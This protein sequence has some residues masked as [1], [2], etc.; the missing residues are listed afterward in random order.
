VRFL[1]ICA[2]D[3][4]LSTAI[5]EAVR[6]ATLDGVLTAASLMVGAPAAAQAVDIARQL[7]GLKVG[8]HVVL[9]DGQA[10]LPKHRIPALVDD[11]GRFRNGMLLD[12]VQFY[13]RRGV[14]EQLAAEIRAQFAAFARTGLPL[15]H[16]NAHK[17]F[18]LHPGILQLIVEIGRPY[19]ACAVRVPQEPLWFSSREGGIASLAS[20]TCLKPWLGLMRRRL[21]TSGMLYNDHVFGVA[22]SGR[23]DEG[24][25]L[26]ILDRLPPGTTEIYLH[27]ATNSDQPITPSMA[28]YR[29][30]DELAALLSPRV[31]AAV[32]ATR[33]SLGGYSDLETYVR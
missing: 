9:A 18:Q 12:A 2:D 27:P 7:P 21:R 20:S 6:R 3:F 15:D 11:E 8:L 32:A 23:L 31:A 26:S 13:S 1:I 17:H 16:V 5:N 10:M 28:H 22:C 33:A 19:G 29:H 30:S 24:V 25:M 14:R 4:G